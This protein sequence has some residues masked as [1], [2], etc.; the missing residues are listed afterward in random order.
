MLSSERSE[1]KARGYLVH[2]A[3][4]T[5]T[6][7]THFRQAEEIHVSAKHSADCDLRRSM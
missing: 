4:A 2:T 5:R 7:I 6:T 1:S 3:F